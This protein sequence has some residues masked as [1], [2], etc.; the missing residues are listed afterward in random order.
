VSERV[1]NRV[2]H[3]LCR[4]Q[5]VEKKCFLVAS[6]HKLVVGVCLYHV[7]VVV[8]VVV[9]MVVV[10]AMTV[11][12]TVVMPMTTAKGTDLR[13]GEPTEGC[14]MMGCQPLHKHFINQLL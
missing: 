10:V 6:C 14:P 9:V 5:S 3:V 1:R 13:Q 11:T 7:M 12:V 2:H 4:L 8:V